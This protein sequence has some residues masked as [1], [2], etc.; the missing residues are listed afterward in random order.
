[1]ILTGQI[2]SKADNGPVP[3]ASIEVID[4]DG[5][6]L[7]YGTNADASGYFSIDVPAAGPGM[8][9]RLSSVGFTTV[10]VPFENFVGVE[11]F[12][13]SPVA[14]TLD[15]IVITSTKQKEIAAWM[16]WLGAAALLVFLL[17]KS[18]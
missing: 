12:T 10:A 11:N 15:E 18:R 4:K 3:Y 16:P 7:G 9:F 5:I 14:Q 8:F 13:L 17:R 1:M 6:Y 2:I